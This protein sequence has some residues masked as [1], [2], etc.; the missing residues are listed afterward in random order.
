MKNAHV[1]RP[2][3]LL[4]PSLP[5]PS[6]TFPPKGE[7][8]AGYGVGPQHMN[9]H[10]G[11]SAQDRPAGEGRTQ[12]GQQED[13]DDDAEEDAGGGGGVLRKRKEDEQDECRGGG[14]SKDISEQ[15]W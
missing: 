10:D 6:A 11:Q 13:D 7:F 1:R 8:A 5:H 14:W 2:S 9:D 15:Q 12:E 4:H 3:C